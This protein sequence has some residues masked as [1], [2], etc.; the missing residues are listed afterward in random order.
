ML[1]KWAIVFCAFTLAAVAPMGHAQEDQQ[2]ALIADIVSEGDEGG[3][4]IASGNVEVGYGGR[5]LR[6]DRV[7]YN[8]TTRRVRATGNVVITDPD[9][10][11]QFADEIEVN[12]KLND[13]YAV[14]F[15][16]R[17]PLGGVASANSAVRQPNGVNALDQAIYTACEICEEEGSVPTWSLRARRAVLNENNDII[18]YRDAVLEVAGIPVFYLPYFFHPD[19]TSGRKSGLL[20]PSIGGSGRLGAFYGQPYYKVLSASSDITVTPTLYTKV[21]PLLEASYRKRF[22][23]GDLNIE[24]SITFES[25]FDNNGNSLPGSSDAV[26]GHVFGDGE[27]RVDDTW[28]W[29]FAAEGASDDLFTRR[30]SIDGGRT[31]RG[32]F[33]GQPRLFLSQLYAVGQTETFYSE[34]SL[35][36]FQDLRASSLFITEAPVTAPL[37][38]TEK[39]FDL[40]KYGRAN[41][42][43]SSAVLLRDRSDGITPDINPDS[44]RFSIGADWA[45]TRVLPGG[46]VVEPFADVR[47][48]YYGLSSIAS[49]QSN[50]ERIVGSVGGKISWPLARHGKWV[51]LLIEPTILGA[52]GLANTNDDA[53]PN[54]DNQLFEFDESR[55]FESNGFSN[56]DLYEGD[57]RLSVGV[58]GSARFRAGAKVDFIAGRRWRSRT[59]DAFDVATNLN[60]R[61]SDWVS[62]VSADFGRPL[63]VE[64]RFRFDEDNFS[65]NRVD[66]RIS[67]AIS[68]FRAS[69]RYFRVDEDIRPDFT[70]PDEG[71]EFSLGAR[72]TKNYSLNYSQTTDLFAN[73]DIRRSVGLVYQD[74]CSRFEIVYQRSGVVDRTIAG[75][76]T[77]LFRFTLATIGEF[78]GN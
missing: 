4:V 53:I 27:F 32:L 26:R 63:K 75:N 34:T 17:L 5:L 76:D 14:G 24:G 71:I 13:G 68:R 41:V 47:G 35:L 31:K 8:R 6:A 57:G 44:R 46:V 18:S 54:E 2:V 1:S 43:A 49:G 73:S 40:G 25:D 69:L 22:W 58:T 3:I 36:F 15:S 28:K 72:I 65:L 55:L 60:G 29:G 21:R 30:Y 74:D 12:D 10:T 56:F 11:Q 39:L 78:G 7:I 52:W 67:S 61:S 33:D 42:N 77:V 48:D 62:G 64:T 51:D 9:G 70:D 59:D 50:V 19:P 45:L 23:A 37:S 16:T 38:F 20:F 66:A